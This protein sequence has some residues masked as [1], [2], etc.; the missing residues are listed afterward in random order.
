MLFLADL[1]DMLLFRECLFQSEEMESARQDFKGIMSRTSLSKFL[2]SPS[3]GPFIRLVAVF[4]SYYTTE[5]PEVWGNVIREAIP[6]DQPIDVRNPESLVFQLVSITNPLWKKHL[7]VPAGVNMNLVQELTSAL[8]EYQ[9]LGSAEAKHLSTLLNLLVDLRGNSLDIEQT[10]IFLGIIVSNETALALV[11]NL[12][13]NSTLF[14]HI[15]NEICAQDLAFTELL[16]QQPAR[17]KIPDAVSH[18]WDIPSFL[19]SVYSVSQRYTFVTYCLQ[20]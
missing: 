11:R 8:N 5:M 1:T 9:D 20:R 16:L 19:W 3:S 10:L 7:S 2:H 4:C 13:L 15:L 18:E 6:E 14:F 17:E 12:N